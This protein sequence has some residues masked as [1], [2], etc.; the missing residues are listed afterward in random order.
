MAGQHRAKK[1][2]KRNVFRWAALVFTV[3]MVGVSATGYL[4]GRAIENKL[5]KQSTKNPE[6]DRLLTQAKPEKPVTIL[7]I[8]SDSRGQDRGRSDTLMIVR[9]NPDKKV[10]SVISIPRDMRVNIPGYG[11]DKIN[12]AYSL[13][14]AKLAIETVQDFTGM[15]LN[16]YVEVDFQG[17]KRLVNALDGIDINVQPPYGKS[18]LRD[19]EINLDLPKGVQH[20]DGDTAL[21]F[22]RVRHVDDDFG[23]MARQQQFLK[24]VF[25]K[26]VR[27]ASLSKLPQLVEILAENVSTDQGLGFKEMY[28]YGTLMKSIPKDNV[29]MV[30]L[31]GTCQMIGDVSYVIPED[32][33]IAWL[34]DRAKN[35]EPFEKTQQQLANADIVVDVQNGSGAAGQ[36]GIMADVLRGK[37]FTVGVVTNAGNFNYER[38]QI[39]AGPEGMSKAQKVKDA[40]GVGEI[41]SDQSGGSI[42][43]IV[44]RDFVSKNGGTTKS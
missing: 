32:E 25:D 26:A 36:G 19:P 20:L 22:V 10:T 3:L 27:P 1:K 16:H 37:G 7:V 17:F 5:H 29:H 33:K 14:G 18:R 9:V 8:G 38:T 43:I 6:I 23:R 34:I 11:T 42:T 13:G 2:S 4:Y 41:I 39:I 12:A 30:T 15:E 21:K 35:D 40:L 44:G 31:P 28:S 24:A